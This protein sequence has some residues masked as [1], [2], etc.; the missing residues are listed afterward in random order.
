MHHKV[1]FAENNTDFRLLRT[2]DLED[3]GFA[4]VQA[5]TPDEALR[6]LRAGNLDAAIID[7]RLE[8]DADPKDISG[9]LLARDVAPLLPKIV[10]TDYPSTEAVRIALKPN[11]GGLPAAVDFLTKDEGP[12]AMV[13]ALRKAV[14]FRGRWLTETITSTS[15][16]LSADYDAAGEQAR[17][18]HLLSL[19]VAGLGILIVFSG[20]GLALAGK[21]DVGIAS[22]VGG[23]VTEGVSYLFFRR[24]DS[25]NERMDAYHREALDTRRFESLLAACDELPSQERRLACT[26]AV[27][28]ASRQRW[29]PSQPESVEGGP[30]PN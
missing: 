17:A 27:I 7:I 30:K 20:T 3:A 4:V 12:E 23:I 10:L 18:N 25:A 5:S 14:R 28:A 16:A 13:D 2:R 26:E 19:V 24:V 6:L 11:I 1:L 15:D 29:L 21:T 22:A 9:L 8:D